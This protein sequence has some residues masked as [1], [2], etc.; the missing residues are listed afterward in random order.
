MPCLLLCIG[1]QAELAPQLTAGL[2]QAL[3]PA[4]ELARG[5]GRVISKPAVSPAAGPH[6]QAVMV[7]SI[8]ALSRPDGEESWWTGKLRTSR[9]GKVYRQTWFLLLRR[10]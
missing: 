10:F 6:T 8:A 2:G 7:T 1:L 9:A 3:F 5:L 4:S